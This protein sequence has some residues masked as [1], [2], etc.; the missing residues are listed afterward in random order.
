M[1]LIRVSDQVHEHLKHLT[2]ESDLSVD[3]VLRQ[4]LNIDGAQTNR[5]YTSRE[6]LM[7]LEIY[8][9]LILSAF[10]FEAQGHGLNPSLSRRQLQTHVEK[11]ID[12]SALYNAWPTEFTYTTNPKAPRKRWKVRFTNVL[13][14]LTKDGVLRPSTDD[15]NF[16]FREE[17]RKN[18]LYLGL[19]IDSISGEWHFTALPEAVTMANWWSYKPLTIDERLHPQLQATDAVRVRSASFLYSDKEY[20]SLVASL[21]SIWDAIDSGEW[22]SSKLAN[23]WEQWRNAPGIELPGHNVTDL[24]KVAIDPSI[25]TAELEEPSAP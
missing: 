12:G 17:S 19:H 13:R 2:R 23:G 14:Q 5:S 22:D 6:E 1:P 7:P 10:P 15:D 8:R 21:Q 9:W 4:A 24:L 16:L 20:D 25:V 3:A 11:L 18:F